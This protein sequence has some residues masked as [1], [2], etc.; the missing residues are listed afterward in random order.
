MKVLSQTLLKFAFETAPLQTVDKKDVV[1][2]KHLRIWY[3]RY[4]KGRCF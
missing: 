2:T 4:R 3:N 1:L